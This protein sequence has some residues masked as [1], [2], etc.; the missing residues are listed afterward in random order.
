MTSR[1]LPR[2]S[3]IQ[4]PENLA[5]LLRETLDATN[6]MAAARLAE[7][8]H[9]A[10]RPAHGAVLELLD[11]AGTTVSVL[12]ERARMTKQSMAELVRHLEAHGYVVRV[13][14]P[15]D[16]RARLVQATDR[17]DEVLA[18]ARETVAATEQLLIEA[19]GPRRMSRLRDDLVAVRLAV[20]DR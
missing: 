9:S 12:A 5:I 2:T 10:V 6:D 3:A 18:I 11:D 7:R 8:G 15:E 4:R 13:A 20:D 16:G 19:L 14:D 1:R 17:G